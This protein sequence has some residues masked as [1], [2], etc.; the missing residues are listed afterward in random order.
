MFIQIYP[1]HTHSRKPQN[2]DLADTSTSAPWLPSNSCNRMQF[3][4]RRFAV[5]EKQTNGRIP[6]VANANKQ[7]KTH[8]VPTHPIASFSFTP[9][10][11]SGL[12]FSS[13]F[14]PFH[15][16]VVSF[17]SCQCSCIGVSA[18]LYILRRGVLF[19]LCA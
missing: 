9:R 10:A 15:S 13:E 6:L 8:G 12:V 5:L 4:R 2:P 11:P 14:S 3:S 7:K 18:R 17:G 16:V 19:A 1:S